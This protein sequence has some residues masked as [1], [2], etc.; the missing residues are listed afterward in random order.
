MANENYVNFCVSGPLWHVCMRASCTTDKVPEKRVF[1][2][3]TNP[4]RTPSFMAGEE[5]EEQKREEEF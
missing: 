5:E 1:L 4:P 2:G 3:S